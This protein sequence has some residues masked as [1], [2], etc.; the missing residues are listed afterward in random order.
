MSATLG[1]LAVRFGCELRGDPD[2]RIDRVGTL[3]AGEG[4]IGFVSSKAYIDALKASRNSAVIVDARLAA[5]APVAALVSAN[6]HVTFAHVAAFLHP[7]PAETPGVAPTAR[8]APDAKVDASATIGDYCVVGYGAEIGAGVVLGPHCIIG[9]GARVG[10]H[11]RLHPRVTVGDRVSL[12]AR[13]IVHSGAVVGADGFGNARDRDGWVKVP[14]LGTVRVGADVEIGA[15]TTIDR[16]ALDDTV[17]EDGVKL[18]NQIQIA[19]NVVIGAHTAIAACTGIAG[20]TRIGQRCMIGG[21]TGIGGQISLCD[22]VVIAG[23]GM[24]TKSIEK[25][26]FYSSVFPVEEVRTWRRLV[27]RFKRLDSLAARVTMLEG[28]SPDEASEKDEDNG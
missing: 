28:K 24:V 6:P 12:G 10:E 16:G 15:N 2:I 22:D 5:H 20:S 26:G 27:G 18:D 3:E 19:H 17:I 1:Q 7:E 14:Q 21:A 13:C 4:A 8:V 25:P 23:M 11:T 9:R